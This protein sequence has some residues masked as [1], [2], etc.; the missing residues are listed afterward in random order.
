MGKGKSFELMMLVQL[1]F[2]MQ[3]RKKKT[4]HNLNAMPKG[5]KMKHRPKC[6]VHS[7]K[8]LEGNR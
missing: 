2:R 4:N 1:A 7:F 8:L 5:C 6:K 3:K